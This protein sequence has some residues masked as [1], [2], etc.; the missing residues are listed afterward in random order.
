[1]TDNLLAPL[2]LF[3]VGIALVGIAAGLVASVRGA[4]RG[5][6]SDWGGRAILGSFGVLVIGTS[7]LA[8]SLEANE[9]RL[10]GIAGVVTGLAVIVVAS[11]VRGQPH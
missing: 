6:P 8:V 10:A 3:V 4:A 9:A 7:L 5:L 11:R 1:M 2:S